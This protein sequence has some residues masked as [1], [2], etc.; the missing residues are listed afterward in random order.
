M[1][2]IQSCS[3]N[4]MFENDEVTEAKNNFLNSAK[5]GISNLNGIQVNSRSNLIFAKPATLNGDY[6]TISV[7]SLPESD[8][9]DFQTLTMLIVLKS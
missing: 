5:M 6:A 2:F 1:K 9:T 7:Y 4:E 8:F 3:N